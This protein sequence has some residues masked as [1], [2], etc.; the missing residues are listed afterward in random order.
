MEKIETFD[1]IRSEQFSATDGEE[2]DIR[3]GV[4]DDIGEK[5]NE[6]VDWINNLEKSFENL[7]KE[8]KG[9]KK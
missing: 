2:Q 4:I 3:N 9:G 7:K 1:E 8:L 5:I 6:I